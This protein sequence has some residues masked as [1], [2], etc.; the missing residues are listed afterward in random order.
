MSW[1]DIMKNIEDEGT[2]KENLPNQ[3]I[4]KKV[5]FWIKELQSKRTKEIIED[6][7][8][9]DIFRKKWSGKSLLLITIGTVL[10]LGVILEFFAILKLEYYGN[11]VLEYLNVKSIIADS[12]DNY[13]NMVITYNTILTAAVVFFYSMLDNRRVGIPYR[14]IISYTFGSKSVPIL[15]VI[16]LLGAFL[17]YPLLAADKGTIVFMVATYIF[18]V[19]LIIIYI[20]LKSTSFHY[21]IKVVR[22]IEIKQYKRLK[23]D[24][25]IR[26]YIWLYFLRHLEQAVQSN[27]ISTDKTRMVRAVLWV[28]FYKKKRIWSRYQ[29]SVDELKDDA[30]IEQLYC[31]YYENLTAVFQ[32]LKG[33]N[34]YLKRNEF[35]L[36]LYEFVE[37]LGKWQ[38]REYGDNEKVE[39]IFLIVVSGIMNA[40]L[41][42]HTHEAQT[43]CRYILDCC[44]VDRRMQKQQ[45]KL[46]I[47]SWQMAFMLDD[48]LKISEHAGDVNCLQCWSWVESKKEI[49]F[50]AKFWYI[51]MNVYSLNLEKRMEYFEK[52]V[53]MMKGVSNSSWPIP[54]IILRAKQMRK[55][56][57]Y[58]NQNFT[59]D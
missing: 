21:C 43:V 26:E 37:R 49:D 45:V 40:I 4:N 35:Y 44:I 39:E 58:V 23:T 46:Y 56:Q 18:V 5:K 15:F 34:D 25:E 11:K 51:W 9:A 48:N 8:L 7:K 32:H 28:P 1:G 29:C 10:F 16:T 47:L 22:E 33:K 50:Y 30:S 17:I 54:Y 38:K 31:F 27:E 2:N 42:S 41:A 24:T 12:V 6:K 20:I 57:D 36:I 55:E 13:C 19:Q 14:T 53:L 3:P 52:A 59:V